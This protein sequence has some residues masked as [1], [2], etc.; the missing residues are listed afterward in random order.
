[1]LLAL[2]P[3][4]LLQ[5]VLTHAFTAGGWPYIALPP[6]VESAAA[7]P[8]ELL[9]AKWGYSLAPAGAML[10]TCQH[11]LVRMPGVL[12]ACKQLSADSALPPPRLPQRLQWGGAA[13]DARQLLRDGLLVGVAPAAGAAAV[14]AAGAAAVAAAEPPKA[15]HAAGAPGGFLTQQQQQ[16][17]QQFAAYQQM[18]HA[19]LLQQQAAMQQQQQHHQPPQQ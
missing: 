9:Q 16:Q 5:V 7:E 12:L 8:R 18:I 2:P 3:L 14:A 17:Q 13:A 11:P 1:M 6:A 10:A 19:A 15:A 4:L